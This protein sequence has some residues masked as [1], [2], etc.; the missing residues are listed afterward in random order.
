MID[1]LI[2]FY[3]DGPDISDNENKERRC[4]ERFH[5]VLYIYRR[6]NQYLNMPSLNAL[7]EFKVSFQNLGDEERTLAELKMPPDDLPLPDHEPAFDAAQSP[8][9]ADVTQSPSTD[10]EFT[11]ATDEIPMDT[12]APPPEPPVEPTEGPT[13]EPASDTDFLDLNDFLGGD[14]N[15]KEPEEI[16][17]DSFNDI[18]PDDL[19]LEEAP[20]PEGD[21]TEDSQ[22]E[23]LQDQGFQSQ[24]STVPGDNDF[25]ISS[26]LLDDFAKELEA[27]DASPVEEDSSQEGIAASDETVDDT[28]GGD[29]SD[30]GISDQGSTDLPE[31]DLGDI[32]E[33]KEEETP[34]SGEVADDTAF[35]ISLP[36]ELPAFEDTGTGEE[37]LSGLGSDDLGGLD[38]SI[39]DFEDL[40]L[41]NEVP[42]ETNALDLGDDLNLDEI[43]EFQEE[44]TPSSEETTA[45]PDDT[46]LD[47]SLD[48]DEI[49]SILE[50]NAKG[51]TSP[52]FPLSNDNIDLGNDI[53]GDITP[54]EDLS[55]E[56][57]F[58]NL[59]NDTEANLE[60][61]AGDSFD[62]FNLDPGVVVG[63]MDFEL[64]FGDR[65]DRLEDIPIPGLDDID[66]EA[67]TGIPSRGKAKPET[68]E[69]EEINLST[70]ELEKLLTTLSSYPLNLRIA[71]EESIAEQMVEPAQMSKL[72]R[73]L[74]AGAPAEETAALVSKILERHI[75]IPK[76]YEKSS[77]EALEAEQASFAYIFVHNFLPV[78]GR[79]IV[80]AGILFCLGFLIWEFIYTPIR[81]EQI[82]KL[83]IERIAD[84]EY[85]RANERFLEAYNI[86]PKKPW[87]YTYARAFRDARQYTLADEKYRELLYFTANRNK[88]NIPEKAAVLE[89]A[90]LK[91]NYIGDYQSADSIIRRNIL[92]YN[93]WDRDALL[94]VAN[95]SLEW[96][97]YEP[98]RLEDA[99]EALAKLM[100]RYGRTDPLMEGMLKYFI[101]TDN[102]GYVLNVKNYFMDS[103]RRITSAT[104][105]ELGGYL[106][107]KMTQEVR[108]VPNEFLA[109]IMDNRTLIEIR[110]ILL[111]AIY[112]DGM[113]P[114]SYYHLARYYNYFE[115]TN[116]ESLTLEVAVR[117]FEAAR[118]ENT[119][120]IEYHI[121]TLQRYA[122]IQISRKEFFPAEETL[123]KGINLYRDALSRR[124]LTQAP[125][126]G[127]LY[128]SLGD[129]EYFV[130]DG[131]MQS[132]LDY[133]NLGEENGWAPPE[134]QYRIGAA[135]YQ[136]RQW[137][138]ALERFFTAYNEM[139]PNR[140]ILYALGN[141][142]YMRG[143]YFAAQGYYD[144]L[145]EILEAD[146]TRLPPIMATDNEDE[147]D[148]AERLMIAQ[149]NLGVALE[150]LSERTG[151]N[152]YRSRALGLYS[153]S[154]RAW[155]ILT[156]NPTTMVRMRPSPDISAPSV[157]PAYLNV[158]N[159]LRPVS[160]YEPQIFLKIDKDM[161]EPSAWEGLTTPGYSLSEGIHTGR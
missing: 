23:D 78:L 30:Q 124:L 43:P 39:G 116:D 68:D 45:F 49:D 152:T 135:H 147:L 145:L 69:V 75:P 148:L 50:E 127:R 12:G 130:K 38:D 10:S 56:D 155:D 34:S 62:T 81:A 95:N 65:L 14:T 88:Q 67:I 64:G 131:D 76:G 47:E 22:V 29:L 59:D 73:L 114:E 111:R 109:N 31:F 6:I 107:D 100:E 16:K 83:G 97:D 66:E 149:N 120:R 128:T 119:K 28:L 125:E 17:D 72:L 36:E 117:A 35:D 115:N 52:N 77:G 156:R 37:G 48:L 110:Q 79:L 98:E 15:D 58:E 138:P 101:R 108:G 85:S 113:L 24:E 26:D 54:T 63:D 42:G 19:N 143:N 150:A 139:P 27:G 86:R 89:Y 151:D 11:S 121:K 102:L 94:A 112:Q 41:S 70:E 57:G 80:I 3:I 161:L 106:L 118:E 8:S 144:R 140:R 91:T 104:L 71:C 82:Y 134:I 55:T 132:A 153:D 99:R 103:S 123:T 18:L 1:K 90:D 87:F 74:I 21:H 84:G 25:N 46:S 51:G 20:T 44:E 96:G 141:V 32:P 61:V 2:R 7:R 158:Q 160:D 126:F 53:T 93:P 133:Y 154:E 146:R 4:N 129:L 142:S 157:N 136:L 60:E 137:G 122:E 40:G 33:F 13:D 105:A 9:V 5:F 92:E 159:S